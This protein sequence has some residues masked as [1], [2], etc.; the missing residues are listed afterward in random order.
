MNLN[1]FE[2]V[3][4]NLKEDLSKALNWF[5]VN[6]M[7]ANPVKLQVMFLGMGEQP[8]F[9]LE[10]TEITIPLTDKV[11]IDSQSK[12]DDPIKLSVRQQTENSVH[13]HVWL[14]S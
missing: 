5:R 6:H 14:I 3:I 13:S 11:T 12:F 4:L 1:N 2:S 10:I 7:A 9:T 8:K